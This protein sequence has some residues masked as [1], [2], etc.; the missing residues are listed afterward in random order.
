MHLPASDSLVLL[1]KRMFNRRVK[2][3]IILPRQQMCCF[4]TDHEI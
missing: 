4:D 1:A 2:T 3:V